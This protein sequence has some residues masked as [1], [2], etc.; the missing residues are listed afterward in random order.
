M[1][2]ETLVPTSIVS[3]SGVQ[4]TDV[5]NITSIGTDDTDYILATNNNTT[6]DVRFGFDSPSGNLTAAATQTITAVVREFDSGQT[7][8]PT[9]TIEIWETG[10]GAPIVSSAITDVDQGNSDQTV[11]VTFTDANTTDDTG[12]SLEVRLIGTKTGGSPG[13]R[14]TVNFDYLKWDVDYTAGGGGPSI[15]VVMQHRRILGMS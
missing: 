1:A 12:A 3:K 13:A 6:S 11:S 9:I 8:T 4:G 10:G 7:G 15:P 14:N 5:A 2:T